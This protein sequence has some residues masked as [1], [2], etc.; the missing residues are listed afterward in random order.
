MSIV[1]PETPAPKDAMPPEVYKQLE[2]VLR[3]YANTDNYEDECIGETP[4]PNT[5]AVYEDDGRKARIALKWL[6]GQM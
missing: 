2:R 4:E 5:N 3:F 6:R 1:Y